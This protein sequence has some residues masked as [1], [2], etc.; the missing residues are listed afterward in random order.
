MSATADAKIRANC[1]GGFIPPPIELNGTNYGKISSGE[2]Q[3]RRQ[4]W[5]G[6][7]RENCAFRTKR[8]KACRT[9]DSRQRQNV[10]QDEHDS[11]HEGMRFALTARHTAFDKTAASVMIAGHRSL[12][13]TIVRMALSR[14]VAVHRAHSVCTAAH[15]H[16]LPSGRPQGSPEEHDGN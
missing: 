5:R 7:G 10:R 2:N 11:C 9:G 16:A 12:L 4:I 6:H 3:P 8:R 1:S 13:R 15:F 14:I